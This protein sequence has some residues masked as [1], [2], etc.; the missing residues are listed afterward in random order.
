MT[1]VLVQS[2]SYC[3]GCQCALLDLHEDLPGVLSKIDILYDTIL[4]DTKELPEV[5]VA[6]IEGAIM[7]MAEVEHVKETREKSKVVIALGSCATYGGIPGLASLH[8]SKDIWESVYKES[9]TSIDNI[10]PS[11]VP[12]PT[13]RVYPLQEFIDVDYFI[14]GCPPPAEVIGETLTALVEGK[15]PKRYEKAVCADCKR[16]VKEEKLDH[17][18]R[19]NEKVPDPEICLLSQ[20][21]ICRGS[22]TRGGCKAPCP[23]NGVT[24]LGCRGPS[25]KVL[26]GRDKDPV[27]ELV[28]RISRLTHISHD[29]VEKQVHEMV[30]VPHLF[31]LYL[32]SS[33]EVRL[34]PRSTVSEYIHRLTSEERI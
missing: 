21:F 28:D 19:L 8:K 30:S 24:C 29:E 16:I 11:E 6:L 15:E 27:T 23:S 22:V 31:Y 4:V 26:K 12:A 1:S 18:F 13:P 5:D 3:A 25:D 10:L 20:G 2:L 17:L 7:N 33:P 32:M 14:T 9:I 34:R